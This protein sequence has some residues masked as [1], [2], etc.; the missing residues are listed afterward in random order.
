M[1]DPPFTQ[2]ILLSSEWKLLE[3]NDFFPIIY[4]NSF[5][6]FLVLCLFKKNYSIGMP[7]SGNEFQLETLIDTIAQNVFCRMIL[8]GK[9]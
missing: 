7:L 4:N 5:F 9:S 1:S 2:V 6:N 8:K 3:D